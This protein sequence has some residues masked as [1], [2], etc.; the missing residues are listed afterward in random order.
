MPRNNIFHADSDLEMAKSGLPPPNQIKIPA[1]ALGSTYS[2]KKDFVIIII[3]VTYYI[4]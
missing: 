3:I 2:R 4:V 1:T